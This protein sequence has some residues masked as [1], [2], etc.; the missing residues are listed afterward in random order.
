M[1]NL[2]M[3]MK[4]FILLIMCVFFIVCSV[5]S[6]DCYKALKKEFPE[7]QIYDLNYNNFIVRTQTE[8]YF[9]SFEGSNFSGKVVEYSR[10]LLWEEKI[11]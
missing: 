6:S 11:K 1:K 7:S 2:N 4:I 9:F 8:V 10:T 5:N 3:F